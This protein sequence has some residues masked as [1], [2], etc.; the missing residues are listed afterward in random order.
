MFSFQFSCRMALCCYLNLDFENGRGANISNHECFDTSPKTY[1]GR[2]NSHRCK[3][4]RPHCD[5]FYDP[6]NGGVDGVVRPP[7]DLLEE[8]CSD[9]NHEQVIGIKEDE[10]MSARRDSS[11]S[12][13][14]ENIKAAASGGSAETGTVGSLIERMLHLLSSNFDYKQTEFNSSS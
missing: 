7:P 9:R 12:K 6:W 5:V 4:Y 10:E 2:L 8:A 11:F 3:E 13:T 14:A 1:A